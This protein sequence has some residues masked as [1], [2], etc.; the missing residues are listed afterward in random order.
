MALGLTSAG[1]G[2]AINKI[3]FS[4]SGIKFLG[5]ILTVI[6][7]LF[8]HL[9]NLAINLLGGFVHTLRLHFVEFFNKFYTG[10][11][12]PF[13]EFKEEYKYITIIED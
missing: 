10:G 7:L 3:A 1:I 9:F 5:P 11:G 12:I 8:G 4:M 13:R 6:V 2:V